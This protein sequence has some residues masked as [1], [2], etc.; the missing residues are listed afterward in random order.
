MQQQLR[1]SRGDGHQNWSILEMVDVNN[2]LEGLGGMIIN[3]HFPGNCRNRGSD[4]ILNSCGSSADFRSQEALTTAVAVELRAGIV[5][6][7]RGCE[8]TYLVLT[9]DDQGYSKFNRSA[10]LAAESR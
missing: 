5:N 7:C 10:I 2:S 1:A 8:N 4:S 9:L 6:H 3:A